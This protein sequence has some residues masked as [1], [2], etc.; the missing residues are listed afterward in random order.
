MTR[1]KELR[2]QDTEICLTQTRLSDNK[3]LKG[4]TG[5]SHACM[6]ELKR[7]RNLRTVCN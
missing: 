6:V 1:E 7:Q 2:F 4:S 3:E 5:K